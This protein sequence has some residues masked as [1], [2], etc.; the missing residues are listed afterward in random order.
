MAFFIYCG[1]IIALALLLTLAADEDRHP[2]WNFAGKMVMSIVAICL[3]LVGF[4]AG[5]AWLDRDNEIE[6]TMTDYTYLTALYESEV[7]A[8]DPANMYRLY[9]DIID[10][11]DKVDNAHRQMNSDFGNIFYPKSVWED[12]PRIDL[13]L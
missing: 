7:F 4:V 3:F 11:N 2:G 9:E 6:K 5:I 1:G 12:V 8:D 10:Y 13:K